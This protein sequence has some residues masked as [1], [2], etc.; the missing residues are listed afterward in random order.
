MWTIEVSGGYPYISACTLN[1]ATSIGR[2]GFLGYSL[3]TAGNVSAGSGDNTLVG[4]TNSDLD[5]KQ[6][7]GGSVLNINT[8]SYPMIP[9]VAP[10]TA[11]VP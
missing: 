6:L 3:T 4:L 9:A 7:S 5:I 10:G 2:I 11:M 1:S 8:M